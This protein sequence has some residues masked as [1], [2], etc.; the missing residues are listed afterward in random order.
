MRATTERK[1]PEE[2]KLDSFA[3]KEDVLSFLY[4]FFSSFPLGSRPT[5]RFFSSFSG[6]RHES[7]AAACL[8]FH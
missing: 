1:L 5:A 7:A 3:A 6:V 2:R 8:S 4:S